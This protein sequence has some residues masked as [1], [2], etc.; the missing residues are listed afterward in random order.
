[1]SKQNDVGEMRDR[2]LVATLPHTAF[3]GWTRAAL[4]AGA[5]DAGQDEAWGPEMAR[6]AFPGGIPDLV[7]HLADWTDRRMDEALA[8]MDLESMRVRDRIAAGVR[9]RLSVLTPYREGVRRLLSHLALPLNA[10]QAARLTWA[11][12]DAIWYGVGDQSSD[13]N[14][15]TKR[16]L[17]APVYSTTVLYWLADESEGF[18]DTWAYLD[19]RIAD[20][21]KIPA[22]TSRIKKVLSSLPGPFG[23]FRRARG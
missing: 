2:I 3:D 11:A 1:M 16:G 6:R 18:A 4:N 21:L 7:D 22:A 15:Y 8:G 17:L 12:A 9:V 10:P 5:T 19:R 14:F 23:V 13:F 20:A